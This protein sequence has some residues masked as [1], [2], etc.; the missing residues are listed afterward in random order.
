[1]RNESRVK[2]LDQL[3]L[4]LVL[5]GRIDYE[6]EHEHEHEYEYEHEYGED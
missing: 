4:D 5:P 2:G 1:M 3:S 6:Y